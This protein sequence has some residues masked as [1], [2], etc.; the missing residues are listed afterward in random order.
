LVGSGFGRLK[1]DPNLRAHIS[2]LL[3]MMVVNTVPVC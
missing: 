2:N 1:L 3:L